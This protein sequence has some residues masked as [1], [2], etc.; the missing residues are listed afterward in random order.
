MLATPT[1]EKKAMT[2]AAPVVEQQP[3]AGDGQR[4]QRDPVAEAVLAGEDVEELAGEE[5]AAGLAR[6]RRS[7]RAARGRAPRGSPS[8]PPWQSAAPGRAARR[9]A[10]RGCAG[11]GRTGQPSLHRIAGSRG[12][13]PGGGRALYTAPDA[14]RCDLLVIAMALLG[15]LAAVPRL[16]TA[17]AA[18]HAVAPAPPKPRSPPR[19]LPRTSSYLVARSAR[20]PRAGDPRRRAGHR[21]PGDAAGAGRVRA[22]RR[23][24]HAG[25]SRCR[26]SSRWSIAASR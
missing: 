18:G 23:W 21:V 10:A 24:R 6:L 20:R 5:R 16:R 8:R 2:D 11:I 9:A 19:R 1:S 25:S 13:R 26:S 4:R 12:R 14:L 15:R 3:V 17:G 7:A 22:G